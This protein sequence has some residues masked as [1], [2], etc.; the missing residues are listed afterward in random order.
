MQ[1]ALFLSRKKGYYA[2]KGVADVTHPCSD[3]DKFIESL[4]EAHRIQ[5]DRMCRRALHFDDRYS[6]LIE[7]CIQETYLQ[8]VKS[9]ETLKAHPNPKAWLFKVCINRLLPYAKLQRAHRERFPYSLDDPRSTE[10]VVSIDVADHISDREAASEM[11][12]EIKATLSTSEMQIFDARFIKNLSIAETAE[13]TALTQGNVRVI[14]SRIRK[15]AKKLLLKN[16]FWIFPISIVTI[17]AL[18]YCTK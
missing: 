9:Y 18:V 1:T 5:L 17:Q 7:E 2:Q 4:F 6:D 15:K 8:A 16:M 10:Q 11:T 12:E 13:A 14:I 3:R